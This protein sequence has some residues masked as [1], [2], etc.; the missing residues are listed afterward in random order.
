LYK[1]PFQENVADFNYS[2][3][4]GNLVGQFNEGSGPKSLQ[5]AALR[6][7]FAK[8]PYEAWQGEL[9]VGSNKFV[10]VSIGKKFNFPLE[11]VTEP[12]YRFAIGDLVES[13]E[14]FGSI[15]NFKKFRA[16]AA[17]GLDDA[18]LLSHRLQV[19]AAVGAAII[20]NQV[21]L[22]IGFAF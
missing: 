11:P 20:G 12:Y 1:N 6:F 13:T 9:K 18:F 16:V 4:V 21:E 14:G 10:E 7:D 5:F 22:S 3:R 15:L 8:R 19:E 17:I 2:V